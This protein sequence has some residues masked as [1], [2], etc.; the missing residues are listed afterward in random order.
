M[1]KI[2]FIL[3]VLASSTAFS[4]DTNTV[5]AV[6]TPKSAHMDP[7]CTGLL[8][9][10]GCG[11]DTMPETESRPFNREMLMAKGKLSLTEIYIAQISQIVMVLPPS[12]FNSQ[13][14]DQDVPNNKFVKA[15]KHK[16][17]LATLDYNENLLKQYRDI[18]PYTDKKDLVE[19]ILFL[20][21]VM[22]KL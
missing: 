10:S 22:I 12:A 1:K 3:F 7:E 16:V 8:N 18:I 17:Y 14:M 11:H 6:S 2:F 15:R 13:S 5:A 21:E 9:H 20:Q 19:Q 4:Q